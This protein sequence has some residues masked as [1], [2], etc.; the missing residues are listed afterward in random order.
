MKQ[1]HPQ[2]IRPNRGE[3]RMNPSQIMTTMLTT[4][5]Y[6]ECQINAKL[7]QR[8]KAGVN[9][10]SRI[11]E[12]VF[13]KDSFLSMVQVIRFFTGTKLHRDSQTG[14]GIA[15]KPVTRLLEGVNLSTGRVDRSD[16]QQF[17]ELFRVAFTAYQLGAAIVKPD[18]IAVVG[19][20]CKGT[21]LLSVHHVLSV[22]AYESMIQH[23]FQV[24]Q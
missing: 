16:L 19:M 17:P 20:F 2:P 6:M 10:R 11:R 1:N 14:K 13:Q 7:N 22:D 23:R 9:S 8:K 3:S 4:P 18:L 24:A 12:K 15:G 5:Q 21:D